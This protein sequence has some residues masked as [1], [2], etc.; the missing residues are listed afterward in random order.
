MLSS[1]LSSLTWGVFG[2]ASDIN[3]NMSFAVSLSERWLGDNGKPTRAKGQCAETKQA[4]RLP[5]EEEKVADERLAQ[6]LFNFLSIIH[7]PLSLTRCISVNV[8]TAK[9]QGGSLAV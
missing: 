9:S 3:L 6:G 2:S 7:S 1:I 5:A 4:R 8:T